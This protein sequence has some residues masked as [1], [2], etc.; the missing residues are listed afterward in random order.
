[1][2]ITVQ[3]DEECLT[4]DDM[5][6]GLGDQQDCITSHESR[7]RH[8]KTEHNEHRLDSCSRSRISRS[9][10]STRNPAAQ[11][12]WESKARQGKEVQHGQQ[13]AR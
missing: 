11:N 7:K 5:R 3:Y 12:R 2:W 13:H 10:G 1:M 4:Y 6:K 9:S 8:D